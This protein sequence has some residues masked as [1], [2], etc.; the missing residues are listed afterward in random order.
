MFINNETLHPSHFY[1]SDNSECT[2][3]KENGRCGLKGI[4]LGI[5]EG[6]RYIPQSA[7]EDFPHLLAHAFTFYNINIEYR[8]GVYYEVLDEYSRVNTLYSSEGDLYFP[9]EFRQHGKI[10]K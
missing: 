3:Q 1:A 9:L 2:P 7:E 4:I 8:P 5:P 6:K 10:E